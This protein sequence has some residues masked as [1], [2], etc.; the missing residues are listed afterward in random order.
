MTV[1]KASERF[2]PYQFVLEREG[3]T[4]AE[5]AKKFGRGTICGYLEKH[6]L[7]DECIDWLNARYPGEA[8]CFK[9]RGTKTHVE[10][11]EHILRKRAAGGGYWDISPRFMGRDSFAAVMKK[12]M[13]SAVHPEEDRFLSAREFM[14]LMG[15]PHDFEVDS[16][17]HLNHIA[18]NVPT[19]TA[20]DMAE[21]VIK[22]IR[23]ELHDTEFSFVKQCN[24]TQTTVSAELGRISPV[25]PAAVNEMVSRGAFKLRR[26]NPKKKLIELKKLK[27]LTSEKKEIDTGINGIS[28]RKRK[29]LVKKLSIWEEMD[30]IDS[31][32]AVKFNSKRK[33][34]SNC[35]GQSKEVLAITDENQNDLL[36]LSST[37]EDSKI[38][39]AKCES[40]SG[41]DW[42]HKK[43]N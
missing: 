11:L 6:H 17:K 33:E 5:F 25:S 39:G 34:G 43:I 18:Q 26:E 23:G 10:Y 30:R 28:C 12:T 24:M 32:F 36:M 4:H 9:R 38:E 27:V 35:P 21:E 14:H 20:S 22:F 42:D 31:R 1:G 2:R 7:I 40:M 13:V 29:V 8:F 16:D 15:L 37:T 41:H 19:N 3:I